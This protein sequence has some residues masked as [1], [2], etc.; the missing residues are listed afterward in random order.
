M[1][2]VRG[3]YRVGL[4]GAGYI[5]DWHAKVLASVDCT[6]LAAVCDTALGRAEALAA[7]TGARPYASLEAML[8][9]ESLD[10]VHILL[11][12]HLHYQ[13][14]RTVIE[15]GV[16][17]LLEKPM[18][19]SAAQCD[20]LIAL[21]AARGVKVGVSHNFLFSTPWER[22]R[23]DVE[24]GLLGPIDSIRIEWNRFLPQSVYGP[25]DTW[26]LRD[27]RNIAL[28]IGAHVLS[29]ADDLLGEPELLSVRATDALTLPTGVPF[30][31]RWQIDATKGRT[32]IEARMRFIPAFAEFSV[33]VRGALA[34]ATA[35][36]ERNTYTLHRHLPKDMDFENCARV[37]EEARGAIRQARR[38]LGSY[39]RSKLHLEKRGTPYAE[40]IGRAM[41]AFYS[42]LG[43]SQEPDTR[44]AAATGAR[45][46][47]LCERVG[48]E[49]NLPTVE[50]ASSAPA[51]RPAKIL[52]LGGTG[53]IGREV[54]Q[55]LLDAG[56]SVRLMVR[57]A[58]SLPASIRAAVDVVRG[59]T[60]NR[61]ALLA[62]MQ[63][64]ECVLHLA[65]ANV[66][67]WTEYQ[68]Y[69]IA[70]THLVAECALEAGIRR[71]VYTGTIDSYYAGSRAGTITEAT[72][73]DTRI[74]H[75]NLYARAK[76]ASEE[77]LFA[78]HKERC[79]PLVVVRPGIVIGRG[80]SPFHWG[81]GMWWN[82]AVCQ[83]WG[84]GE[85]P[86]PLV[87]VEDVAAGLIA[88]LR[89]PGVEG[90]AFNLVGDVCLT[91]REYL[92]AL[93][94]AGAMRID[95]RTTPILRFYLQDMFKWLVKV[96]VR[97]PER[98]RPSYRDWES[99]T[100]KARFDASAAKTML[101]W[102]PEED[103]ARF[104][105]KGIDAAL[106]EYRK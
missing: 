33:H 84:K 43:S 10:A 53:F 23:R 99:R 27:P 35:D 26:M 21:A 103:R 74:E 55:Q 57:N 15:A 12:P 24:S 52:V 94:S 98:R 80:G 92:D 61:E 49:A 30:Y 95:R 65:R 87:L 46:I 8:A 89:T 7:R 67:T 42:S 9:S 90:R 20:E 41:D 102:Q 72:P 47:R 13:A 68:Q 77:L 59:D 76:A 19:A 38:T 60:G 2:N 93:D 11:P 69:E 45:I 18:C 66:K 81:I 50:A 25:F 14:A 73:L 96:A 86:L 83:I 36:L 54:V 71:F 101:G 91:A 97:F 4:V 106:A 56:E 37:T 79:L 22:L 40:S 85:N 58:S 16:N 100:Q 3:C 31:R 32:S 5:A 17:V 64:V 44:I 6:R 48:R 51:P 88:A 1:N 78:L 105:Q 75:R 62:A 70:A 34:A 104:I 82:D 39:I 29:F 28:E 63:G